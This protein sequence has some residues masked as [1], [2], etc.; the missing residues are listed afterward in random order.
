LHAPVAFRK[1]EKRP[2]YY[3]RVL[4][5][6]TWPGDNLPARDIIHECTLWSSCYGA[7]WTESTCG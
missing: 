1:L 2:A 5:F 7:Q 4:Q 6:Y 3:K